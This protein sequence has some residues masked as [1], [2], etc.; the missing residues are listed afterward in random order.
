MANISKEDIE[1]LVSQLRDLTGEEILERLGEAFPQMADIP[2]QEDLCKLI[3]ELLQS[4]GV[5]VPQAAYLTPRATLVNLLKGKEPLEEIMGGLS[6]DMIELRKLQEGLEEKKRLLLQEEIARMKQQLA[7]LDQEILSRRALGEPGSVKEE[8]KLFDYSSPAPPTPA[9]KGPS[10]FP[11]T[12]GRR[13]KSL[14]AMVETMTKLIPPSERFSGKETSNV[15]EDLNEFEELCR[16]NE[17]PEDNWAGIL[18]FILKDEARRYLR[19]QPRIIQQS[20]T[21]IKQQLIQR[22]M[23]PEKMD[24]LKVEFSSLSL[25]D[26]DTLELYGEHLLRLAKQLPAGYVTEEALIDRLILGIGQ[27]EVTRQYRTSRPRSFAAAMELARVWSKPPRKPKLFA[28]GDLRTQGQS[29]NRFP[30]RSNFDSNWRNT[31]CYNCGR[32]GHFVNDPEC[33]FRRRPRQP[34]RSTFRCGLCTGP[35]R[36]RE[37][38]WITGTLREKVNARFAGDTPKQDSEEQDKELSGTSSFKGGSM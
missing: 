7:S 6:T 8:P 2:S 13:S 10:R 28:M 23:S 11:A 37:C 14:G 30:P 16:A 26:E 25:K 24:R 20:Y 22:Y 3:I 34:F 21:S 35:H 33:P 9:S 32:E 15:C 5:E 4:K 36:T 19:A 12:P 31:R 29:T 1:A 27:E 38:S 17:I 18:P